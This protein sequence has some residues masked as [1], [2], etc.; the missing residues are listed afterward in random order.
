MGGSAGGGEDGGSIMGLGFA[1]M[2]TAE[3]IRKPE[4]V[5][6][7]ACRRE[8][9]VALQVRLATLDTLRCCNVTH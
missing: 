1:E 9:R 2:F 4:L 5:W 8:L 7:S 6:G 3:S